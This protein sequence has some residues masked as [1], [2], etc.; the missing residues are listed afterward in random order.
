MSFQELQ[1]CAGRRKWRKR[2]EDARRVKVFLP[3]DIK[4]SWI[5]FRITIMPHNSDASKLARH[6]LTFKH[7]RGER[8]RGVLKERSP[9][10]PLLPPLA[11][12]V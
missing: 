11:S 7:Q 4:M 6:G 2:E 8:K 1:R 3:Q 9:P 12:M 5:S 10:A